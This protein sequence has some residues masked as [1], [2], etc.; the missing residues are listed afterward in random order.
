M[1]RHH[2]L[3]ALAAVAALVLVG[4]AGFSAS[5]SGDRTVTVR[6]GDT[7][8]GLARRYRVPLDQ[9]ADVNGMQLNDI[10]MIGRKLDI[11]GPGSRQSAPAPTRS[12]T[13]VA[14]TAAPAPRRVFT[15]AD[16]A[17]MRSFCTTYRP[18]TGPV[19]VL[20]SL[21]K[22]SPDRLALRP[23]FVKWGQV[24]RV[25]PDLLEAVAWQESG[26]QNDAVSSAN[27]QGIGQLLPQTAV[28]VNGL[29]GTSLQL[30]FASDNIR[31]QARYLAYLLH[32]TGNQVCE[33]V[34]SYYQGFTTLEHIGVLP[35]SQVY[36]RSVLGLRPRFK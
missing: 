34:A 23:L 16:L 15:A 1:P 7:L 8:W 12:A 26:W 31:M 28:F 29:L 2:L 20:P 18:P 21:L 36:V 30:T 35:E 27:A 22:A 9:L 25:S 19:G 13:T 14:Q 3:R 4:Q 6:A 11:P 32:A 5:A 17:Q 24:Y 10:L 33:A